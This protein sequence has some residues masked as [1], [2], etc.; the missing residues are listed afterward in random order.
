MRACI[1]DLD[2]VIVNTADLHFFA[3][4]DLAKT[5]GVVLTKEDGERQKGVSRLKSLEIVLE[6]GGI[7]G[8]DLH[9]KQILADTKNKMY[10]EMIEK[11]TEKDILPG[12]VDFISGLKKLDIKIA[13]GSA[14]KSGGY[15]LSKLG[16]LDYFDVIVDGNTVDTPKPNPEVFLKGAELLMEKPKCCI[17]IEDSSAGIQAAKAAGMKSI[18]I[19]SEVQLKEADIV[20]SDTSGLVDLKIDWREW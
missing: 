13:L 1:F 8:L 5:L 17:V 6:S 15:I 11:I 14:S 18:G 19:G 16:L 12:I 3:W 10:L 2:G 7:T 9:V 20:V 4:S